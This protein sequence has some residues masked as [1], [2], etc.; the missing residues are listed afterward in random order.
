MYLF[1][2]TWR[3]TT[4]TSFIPIIKSR[5]RNLRTVINASRLSWNL[6]CLRN[7]IIRGK[8]LSVRSLPCKTL[9]HLLTRSFL[10]F[11]ST[12]NTVYIRLFWK[13]C[14][15]FKRSLGFISPAGRLCCDM[16]MSY[17]HLS[18]VLA[19]ERN[20]QISIISR[21][22]D[23]TELQLAQKHQTGTSGAQN[24]MRSSLKVKLQQTIHQ[25]IHNCWNVDHFSLLRVIGKQGAREWVQ[26][27][28]TL[29]C[30]RFFLRGFQCWS[31]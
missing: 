2:N 31:G 20:P 4:F 10:A 29:G 9:I 19:S 11:D 24:K 22:L 27:F 16:E 30:Q 21:N 15:A 26:K 28:N 7:H 5:T 23:D 25:I 3:I 18:F 1:L 8:T 13:P 14:Y 12:S 17:L 6:K